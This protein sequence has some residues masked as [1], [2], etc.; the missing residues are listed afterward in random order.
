MALALL[1]IMIAIKLDSPG[2]VFY[3]SE[4]IEKKGVVF[5]C[6]KFRTMVRDADKRPTV[7]MHVKKCD[8]ELVKISNDPRVNRLGRFLRKYS[9][10]E[11][12]Q[13][14]NVPRGDMSVVGP[15]PP[16]ASKVPTL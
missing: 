10:D 7:F 14:L 15:R 12:P 11:F 13:F 3:T 16:S 9:V 1:A 4:R 8:G 2:P 5:Q 6:I